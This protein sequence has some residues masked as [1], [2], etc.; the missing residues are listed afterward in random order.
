MTAVDRRLGDLAT[1][2]GIPPGTIEA[3][4]F[5]LDGT[6]VETN[7]RWA[8]TL[9]TR[10]EPLKR[11]FPRLDPVKWS[12]GV[13]M[14]IETPTN[15]AISVLERLGVGSSFF[16]LADRIR[17]SKGLATKKGSALIEGSWTLLDALEGR[18]K[19][20]VVTTRARPEAQA[21]IRQS[22]FGSF[23]P[24]V[25]TRQDVWGIKPHPAPV[26]HAARQLGVP[27]ERCVLIGDTS[28]DMRSARR[29]GAYAVG[30]LSGF[31]VREELEAA[32]AHLILD[33]AEQILEHL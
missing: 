9:A 3:I 13:V 12:R 16:G 33:R 30:V 25:V 20:A 15:Y 10:I 27:P 8:E 26:R 18:Y 21:F 7:N 23:F 2:C 14:A 17:K 32:G 22:K 4:L 5:D 29:A 31:G 1:F 6:L 28:M 11:V 19:L 24:V